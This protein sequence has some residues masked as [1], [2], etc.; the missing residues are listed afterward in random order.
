[1]CQSIANIDWDLA[2][3]LIVVENE[4]CQAGAEAKIGRK[5]TREHVASHVKGL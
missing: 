4:S 2:I 3:E 1:M 5:H